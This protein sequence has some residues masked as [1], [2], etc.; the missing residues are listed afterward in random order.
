MI[1]IYN[2]FIYQPILALLVFIYNNLAFNDLGLAILILTAAVR[3]IFSPLFHKSVKSQ[4]IM[5]K[6]QPEIER[7]KN[8]HKDNQQ[9][10]A[11]AL[12]E[13]YRRHGVNPFGNFLLLFVQLPILIALYRVFANEL[14]GSLF[15]NQTFFGLIDLKIRSNLLVVLAAATQYFQSRQLQAPQLGID[16]KTATMNQFMLVIGPIIAFVVLLNLPAAVALYWLVT[17]VFSIGH[18]FYI[19]KSLKHG[20]DSGKN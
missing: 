5:Q 18:Q 12:M 3:F 14:S 7:I 20:T 1:N 15:A 10:Q 11:S 16:P 17:T 6:I 8:H 2:N 9:E 13:L 4:I 19:F